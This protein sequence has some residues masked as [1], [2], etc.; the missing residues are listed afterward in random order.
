MDFPYWLVIV[1]AL[2]FLPPVFLFRPLIVAIANR[3]AGKQV[4]TEELKALRK[5]VDTL[6]AQLTQM[7]HRMI[8]VEDG[9]EFSRK[10]LEDVV[11]KQ[12]AVEADSK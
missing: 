12:E 1:T 3:I 11:K 5:R 2:I 8:T 6:E 7:Q 9:H 4:N 10:L